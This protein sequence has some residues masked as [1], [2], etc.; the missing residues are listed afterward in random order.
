MGRPSGQAAVITH[1]SA[2]VLKGLRRWL[3]VNRRMAVAAGPAAGCLG[4]GGARHRSFCSPLLMRRVFSRTER[5]RGGLP[6]GDAPRAGHTAPRREV[7]ARHSTGRTASSPG[8]PLTSGVS[9]VPSGPRYPPVPGDLL[10]PRLADAQQR[11]DDVIGNFPSDQRDHARFG[12]VTRSLT[13]Q[14]PPHAAVRAGRAHGGRRVI[15]QAGLRHAELAR[16]FSAVSAWFQPWLP[17]WSGWDGGSLAIGL[18][19]A[20]PKE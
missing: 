1:L 8:W 5:T 14:S 20:R 9:L 12:L 15:R 19:V 3:A 18:A 4:R 10:L 2:R 7:T 6:Q 13:T 16:R 11:Y 17:P